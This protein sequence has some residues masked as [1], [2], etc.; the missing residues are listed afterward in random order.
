M[1]PPDFIIINKENVIFFQVRALSATVAKLTRDLLA[2]GN[3]CPPQFVGLLKEQLC[4]MHS[5]MSTLDLIEETKQSVPEA[6]LAQVAAC[7]NSRY[8]KRPPP[9]PPFFLFFYFFPFYFFPFS[10][11]F[12]FF[13][14]FSFLPF[15]SFFLFFFLSSFFSFSFCP[16]KKSTYC[17]KKWAIN[18]WTFPN[19]IVVKY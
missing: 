11:F 8:A 14:S 2:T 18:S 7:W 16:Q 6:V 13:S 5:V 17:T 9:S 10:F 1:P 15:F 4:K 19:N 3:P 12:V